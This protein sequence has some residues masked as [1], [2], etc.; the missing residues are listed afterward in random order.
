MKTLR[1]DHS[2]MKMMD[3]ISLVSKQPVLR[4][5]TQIPFVVPK[6]NPFFLT[7]NRVNNIS[8]VKTLTQRLGLDENGRKTFKTDE[9][10]MSVNTTP[11]NGCGLYLLLINDVI[12]LRDVLGRIGDTEVSWNLD[13][14]VSNLRE[15]NSEKVITK[16]LV[17]RLI[18]QGKLVVKFNVSKIKDHGTRWKVIK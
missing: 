11:Y 14:V 3:F 9:I 2:G 15:K 10:S 7:P 12:Y 18:R 13:T 16:Q 5:T 1:K 17:E 4:T 8:T 6:L